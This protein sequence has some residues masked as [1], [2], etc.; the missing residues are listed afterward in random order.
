MRSRL[1]LVL[2]LPA[3]LLAQ[4]AFLHELP[5]RREP[6]VSIQPEVGLNW[7]LAETEA[8]ESGAADIEA[9]YDN[10][11][12]LFAAARAQLSFPAVALHLRG[13]QASDDDSGLSWGLG[14]AVEILPG[15]MPHLWPFGL[16]MGAFFRDWEVDAVIHEQGQRKREEAVSWRQLRA[17]VDMVNHERHIH[18]GSIGIFYQRDRLP[19]AISF[20]D[21]T[22]S[23]V[24]RAFDSDFKLH[25]LGMSVAYD[26]GQQ[27]LASGYSGWGPQ[28]AVRA[29]WALAW[30]SLGDGIEDQARS[31]ASAS[32]IDA[33]LLYTVGG[34][35]ELGLL[36]QARFEE[37]GWPALQAVLAYRIGGLAMLRE[38]HSDY[39]TVESGEVN[40][41]LGY[42]YFQHGPVGRISWA[43]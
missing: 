30:V 15:E 16:R 19:A 5:P 10:Q 1:A 18:T 37:D 28:F 41:Q 33:P 21:T 6:W 29:D 42:W 22:G 26:H 4:D 36:Y 13:E 23:T 38:E 39:R 35:L 43:F 31:A 27:R 14:A 40:A 20:V 2:L 34:E 25:Q 3:T 24:L 7:W 11:H 32:D 17:F 8:E 9:E 12:Q